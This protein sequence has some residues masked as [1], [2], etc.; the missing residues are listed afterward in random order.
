MGFNGKSRQCLGTD[1]QCK[2]GD[3][4]SKNSKMINV[5]D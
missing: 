1:G 5:R 3:D 2:Q 4:N